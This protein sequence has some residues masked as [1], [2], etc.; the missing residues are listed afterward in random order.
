MTT[1]ATKVNKPVKFDKENVSTLSF[2]SQDVLTEKTDLGKRKIDLQRAQALGAQSK[3]NI[4]IYFSDAGGSQYIVE[5]TVWA[6]T[7]RNVT[8]K[9]GVLIPNRAIYKIGF[10]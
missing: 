4:K 3:S 7:E 8:L 10:F 6:A 5:A 2:S 1:T 9:G